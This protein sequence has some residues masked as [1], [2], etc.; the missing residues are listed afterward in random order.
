MED[1]FKIH[2]ILGGAD[3]FP[4]P[5]ILSLDFKDISSKKGIKRI[6]ESPWSHAHIT[7]ESVT[8]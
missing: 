2:K 6:K 5:V 8:F 4:Y 7:N 3:Q 1:N